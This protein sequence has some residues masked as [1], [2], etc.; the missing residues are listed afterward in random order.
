MDLARESE[1]DWAGLGVFC[2]LHLAAVVRGR[3]LLLSHL[4]A[5][6]AGSAPN[7]RP[8]LGAEAVQTVAAAA[9]AATVREK[10][11][12]QTVTPRRA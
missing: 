10:L 4:L 1:L 8:I 9:A 5:G 3:G 7:L 12:G 2:C 6:E 11:C